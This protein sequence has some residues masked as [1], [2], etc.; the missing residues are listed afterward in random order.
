MMDKV[1][2]RLCA[3]GARGEMPERV[4]LRRDEY[5]GLLFEMAQMD[6]AAYMRAVQ[7]GLPPPPPRKYESG[8]LL[9][10]APW[11]MVELVPAPSSHSPTP[12]PGR[13]R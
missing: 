12:R 9:C 5:M 3:M 7:C 4:V 13:S 11:G 8:R 6:A 1:M 2:E 10:A